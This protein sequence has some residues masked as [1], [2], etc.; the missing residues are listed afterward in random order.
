M[1]SPVYGTIWA[2]MGL[3]GRQWNQ[4]PRQV[5]LAGRLNRLLTTLALKEWLRIGRRLPCRTALS[6]KPFAPAFNAPHY[7]NGICRSTNG[8]VELTIAGCGIV[9]TGSTSILVGRVV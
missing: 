3:F 7:E 2:I 5:P 1:A 8:M 4:A 6:A 9:R